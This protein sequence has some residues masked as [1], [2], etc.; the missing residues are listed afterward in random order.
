MEKIKYTQIKKVKCN[1][2]QL[3]FVCEIVKQNFTAKMIY[4][5]F[6]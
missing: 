6:N 4:H 1:T 2:A 5:N 3:H